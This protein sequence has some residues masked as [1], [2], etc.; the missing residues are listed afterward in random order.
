MIARTRKRPRVES[1]SFRT[2]G[3]LVKIEAQFRVRFHYREGTAYYYRR[4]L[5]LDE[6][7]STRAYRTECILAADPLRRFSS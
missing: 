5:I 2:L 4:K 3:W 6:P 1:V 7:S